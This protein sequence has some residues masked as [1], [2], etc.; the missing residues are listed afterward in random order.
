MPSDAFAHKRIDEV[1]RAGAALLN[2]SQTPLI[3]ARVLLMHA[4]GKDA[5]G[6]IAA[7]RDALTVDEAS[8]FADFIERRTRGEPVAYITGVKEFWSMDFRVTSDVLIPRDDSECLI[9]ALLARL[10]ADEP[11][12]VLDLGTGSGCILGALLRELPASAGVGVDR[13]E[14]AARVA[15]ANLEALGLG[16]RARIVVGD[17]GRGLDQRFGIIIANPPYIAESQRPDLPVDVRGFEPGSAL[18]AGADGFDAY[19]AI[20]ADAPRLLTP[21]G[22]LVFEAGDGQAGR[23]AQMVTDCFKGAD[24]EIIVDLK[25]RERGVLAATRAV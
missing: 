19:R 14:A 23:L 2:D 18:F 12:S 16:D 22:L 17:W 6:L 20:L 3:D 7:G 15:R 5:A 24:I 25:G 11:H 21:G 13:S 10:P 9:E 4:T 1:L 8:R